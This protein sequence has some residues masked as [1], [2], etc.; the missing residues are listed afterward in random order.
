MFEGLKERSQR[1]LSLMSEPG[2]R[3]LLVCAPE[4]VSLGQAG[5]FAERLGSDGMGIAGV[6]VNRAHLPVSAMEMSS[7][8]RTRLDALAS[9][10][11]DS[12]AARVT[13]ALADARHLAEADSR[14]LA[15]LDNLDQ[16]RQ[17]VPHFN[18]DLH[19]MADLVAFSDALKAEVAV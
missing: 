14:S 2:T 4:P 8:D 6:L 1:V 3:I 13:A 17:L 18:R 7:A 9:P 11:R 10:G 12:L 15:L 19:S 5:R 16:P